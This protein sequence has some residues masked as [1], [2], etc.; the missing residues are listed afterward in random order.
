MY[1]PAEIIRK[2]R[3]GQSLTA[4][5]IRWFVSQIVSG[6]ITPAQIGA[7]LM[8]AFLQGLTPQET[9]AL[10]LE[11]ANSGKRFVFSHERPIIDKHSTGGVG[12]TVSLILLPLAVACG[13]AVPM[14]T[15]RSLGHTGGTVDKLESILGMQL[16]FPIERY[17]EFLLQYGGFFAKQTP[18]IAPADR[19]LYQ[20]RDVTA[21]VDSLPLITASILSKKIVEDLDGLVLDIKVGKGA[22]LQSMESAQKLAQQM[23]SVADHI[24]L[25]LRVVFSAMDF[26]LGKAVGNWVEVEEAL[27][28]LEGKGA[29][30][31]M[32]LT[33]FLCVQM[34]LLAGIVSD[35][36]QG[37]R[38]AREKLESG[39]AR[40]VFYRIITAQGGDIP[41]SMEQYK[42]VP[43]MPLVA[44]KTGVITDIHARKIGELGVLLGIGRRKAEDTVDP[45]AGF[46]FEK[47]V[48]DAVQKGEVLLWIQASTEQQIQHILPLLRD[49]IRIEEERQ[50]PAIV[51]GVMDRNTVAA[52]PQVR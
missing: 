20:I 29:T 21:T 3:D 12:D 26:P 36:Q 13:C 47:K 18:E 27:Q 25:P 16:E 40:E 24:G 37:Y 28:C 50:L 2:K 31:L 22:F 7:W 34:L 1:T 51:L 33:L 14:I 5:E 48:G 11:M 8:A 19:Y 6:N 38:L 39:E 43:K 52:A 41:A 46:V 45:A 42:N 23:F 9:A 30:D 49:A 10:T 4:D 44:W 17:S 32:E 15:G 35:G